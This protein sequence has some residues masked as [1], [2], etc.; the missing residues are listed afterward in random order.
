MLTNV[1][2][3]VAGLCPEKTVI[4]IGNGG[5]DV[6]KAAGNGTGISYARQEEQLGTGHA[7]N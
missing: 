2:D 4:I 3:A 7:A 5:D 1:L 6:A